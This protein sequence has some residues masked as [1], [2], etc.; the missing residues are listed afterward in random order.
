MT[1][2]IRTASV[3]SVILFILLVSSQSASPQIYRWTDE[4]GTIHFSDNPSSLPKDYSVGKKR[5]AEKK[6]VTPSDKAEFE[7]KSIL[8]PEKPKP[9]EK[10]E[11]IPTQPVEPMKPITEDK[12][13]VQIKP[14]GENVNKESPPGG[15]TPTQP[16]PKKF[17]SGKKPESSPAVPGN[18]MNRV[19]MK[20]TMKVGAFVGILGFVLSAVGGIW[21]LVAAFKVSVKWGLAC[22]FLAPAQIVF[23]FKHW[24]EA[25]K[26]FAVGLLAMGVI[27]VAVYLMVEDPFVYLNQLRQSKGY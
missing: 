22:L 12:V 2:M 9:A 1:H 25:R 5:D 18:P 20:P 8:P 17:E 3:I 27:L 19:R 15:T 13:I 11:E 16:V 26:P 24:K 21:F 23:L 4:K 6:S 14:T 10:A 7:K